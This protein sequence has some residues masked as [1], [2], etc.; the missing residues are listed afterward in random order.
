MRICDG[1]EALIVMYK[2]NRKSPRSTWS[3]T[4]YALRSALEKYYHIIFVDLHEGILLSSLKRLAWAAGKRRKSWVVAPLYQEALRLKAN[5]LI[6]KYHGVPVLMISDDVIIRKPYYIYQDLSVEYTNHVRGHISNDI[7]GGLKL[8]LSEDEVTRMTAV[9]TRLY[10]NA[11]HTFFMGNWMNIYMKDA[12]PELCGKF[13]AVGGGLNTDFEVDP[14]VSISEKDNIILF[15]GIDFERKGGDLVLKA[16][17]I[18]REKGCNARL[19]IVGPDIDIIETGVECLG[20]V[21]RK[22]LSS[23]MRKASLMCLPSIFEAY[24]LAFPEA[25]CFGIPCI[26]RNRYEMPYFI[27]EGENGYLLKHDDP[28]ELADLMMKALNNAAMLEYTVSNAKEERR[29]Y[30]WEAVAY[31]IHTV[32]SSNK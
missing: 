15:N 23:I 11:E 16:F 18:V 25:L 19:L 12:H 5:L 28:Q 27:D 4:S 9:Q 24:G 29:K 2:D 7:K 17:R 21:T 10:R 3:G 13:S 14:P 31:R 1:K 30:S 32:V 6:A 20:K 26:G 22:E 8:F